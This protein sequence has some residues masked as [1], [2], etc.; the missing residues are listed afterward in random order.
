M[1][2][3]IVFTMLMIVSGEY[4]QAIDEPNPERVRSL[5]EI[6]EINCLAKNIFFESR[7]QGLQGKLAVAAVTFNRGGSICETVYQPYQ[8]SWTHLLTLEEQD[9]IIEEEYDTWAYIVDISMIIYDNPMVLEKS[10][11]GGRTHYLNESEVLRK[12][13]YLP[14]WFTHHGK[15]PVKIGEHTFV[16]VKA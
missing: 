15:Y 9:R 14:M 6:E 13:G 10:G 5:S 16:R 2:V 3:I 4:S 1:K 8:F 12:K 7:D 11:I